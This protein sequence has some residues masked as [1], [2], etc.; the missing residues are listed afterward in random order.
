MIVL[1]YDGSDDARTAADQTI[2]LFRPKQATVLTVS[3]SYEEM[4]VHSGF[5]GGSGFGLGYEHREAT[6]RYESEVIET[7][8]RA[9]DEGARRLRAGGMD[10]VAL[11][12]E[13]DG[14]VG[15][16]AL[17]V[18]ARA[19]AEVLIVGRRGRGAVKSALLGSV[20]A[21]ITEHADRPVLVVPR[22]GR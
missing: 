22:H 11:V 16:T 14:T 10:A 6:L 2:R 21:E 19:D 15:K 3:E 8:R 20:S 5:G 18:A 1:L 13:R 4:L 12:E 17:A 9:A 7:A